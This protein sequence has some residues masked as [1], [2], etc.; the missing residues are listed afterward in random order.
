MTFF[1]AVIFDGFFFF[2]NGGRKALPYS[3]R[4]LYQ[5]F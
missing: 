1:K 2:F 4:S 3:D 5:L